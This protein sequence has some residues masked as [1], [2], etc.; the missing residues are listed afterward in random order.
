VARR[1]VLSEWRGFDLWPAERAWKHAGRTSGAIVPGVLDRLRLEQRL[2]EVEILKVWNRLLDPN[3]ASHAQPV[4]LRR[5][6]LFVA[7][8]S[9]VW[10]TE[11]V[12]FRQRE[13]LERLHASFGSTVIRKISFRLG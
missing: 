12:R 4:G 5:G 7:V 13:I 2:A 9:S 11:I 3:I 10:L 8:D 6:T 1:A